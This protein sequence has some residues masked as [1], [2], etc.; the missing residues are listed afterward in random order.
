MTRGY[1]FQLVFASSKLVPRDMLQTPAE[2][3]A[4]ELNAITGYAIETAFGE[5]QVAIH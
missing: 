2:A 1:S 3:L 4:L 5:S